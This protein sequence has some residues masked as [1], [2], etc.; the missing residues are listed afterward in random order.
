[1]GCVA[2]LAALAPTPHPSLSSQDVCFAVATLKINETFEVA[3]F[4][5]SCGDLLLS[6]FSPLFSHF[7]MRLNN[8]RLP[9]LI[10]VL[11]R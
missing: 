11:V 2:Q 9:V 4:R 1:M 7:L 3:C 10:E 8:C 5:D 6:L